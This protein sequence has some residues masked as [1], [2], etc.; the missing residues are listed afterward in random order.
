MPKG[1][2]AFQSHQQRVDE[3]RAAAGN[4]IRADYFGLDDGEMARVRFLEQGDEMTWAAT[5][6]VPIEG[7]K[8][9]QDLVCLDQNDDGTPCPFCQSSN[10]DIKGRATKG[11]F[12]IIWRGGADTQAEN[13]ALAAQN[14]RQYK[15]A[16]QY[17][18]NDQGYIEKD[19]AGNKVI[20]GFGDGVWLWK[21]SKTVFTMLL[22]KD[23]LYKGLMS[24]DFVILRRGATMQ[25]TTYL[26]EPHI[27]DGGAEPMLVADLAMAESKYDLDELTKPKTWEEAAAILS[28][29]PMG[30]GPQQTFERQ[31]PAASGDVFSGGAPMRSSA[32]TR[33]AG[34]PGQ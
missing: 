30:S 31:A 10:K 14:Q 32:F 26:C 4:Y 21:C 22:E 17:K 7:Q 19:A 6:R 5:H 25:N 28:G 11:F 34:E 15:L 27:V 9:P 29:Q 24:R 8:Y 2:D 13:Q 16:P 33:A 20:N 12:N 18:R 23:N 1:V 3:R